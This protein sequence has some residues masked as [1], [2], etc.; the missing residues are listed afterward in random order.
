[1]KRIPQLIPAAV[2]SALL[3]AFALAATAAPPEHDH[4]HGQAAAPATQAPA[5]APAAAAS[6]VAATPGYAGTLAGDERFQA[7]M[8]RMREQHEKMMA[9]RTPGERQKL[10]AEN[11]RLMQEGM[12]LMREMKPGRGMGMMG[13]AAPEAGQGPAPQ[14]GG[15]MGGQSGAQGGMMGGQPGADTAKD[16]M[17]MQKCMQMHQAMGRRQ[18]MTEML[19]QMMLDQQSAAAPSK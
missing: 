18:E 2:L 9:A 8:K 5:T 14:G 13:P 7:Q 15:M 11:R 10:M 19:L 1:M 16:G 3:P 6:P 17:D 12:D 4:N